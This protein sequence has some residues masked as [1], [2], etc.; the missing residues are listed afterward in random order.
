LAIAFWTEGDDAPLDGVD[1]LLVALGDIGQIL[2]G[3][4]LAQLAKIERV[5]EEVAGTQPGRGDDGGGRRG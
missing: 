4:A 2:S 5:A 1:E 3:P